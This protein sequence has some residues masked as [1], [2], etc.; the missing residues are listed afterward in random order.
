MINVH[1]QI[2]YW[3]TGAQEDWDAA[4][5][6]IENGKTRHGLFFAPLALEKILKAHVCRCTK[7]VPPRI[8]DLGKLFDLA[9]LP[10][11]GLTHRQI[12]VEMN[13]YNLEGR[14]PE[15][16]PPS[17]TLDKAKRLMKISNEVYG[18]LLNQL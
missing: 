9:Q 15:T 14:Y 8:H 3:R 5:L 17:P 7:S 11:G 10:T 12:L 18:W 2:E 4:C 13:Q 6:C 1:K 16:M